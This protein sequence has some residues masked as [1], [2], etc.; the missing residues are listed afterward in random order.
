MLHVLVSGCVPAV[1][2]GYRFIFACRIAYAQ[3][4]TARNRTGFSY[5]EECAVFMMA[6]KRRERFIMQRRAP[7]F[8]LLENAYMNLHLC[9]ARI[10]AESI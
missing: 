2:T 10:S 7:Q 5:M 4:H 9:Q 6:W 3:Y 8:T 1:V